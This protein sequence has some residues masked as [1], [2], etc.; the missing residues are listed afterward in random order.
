MVFPQD[1]LDLTV[2][3]ALDADLTA[4]PSTWVWTDITDFVEPRI[5][6]TG[7]GK[8][9]EQTKASS[10]KATLSVDNTDGRFVRR[11]PLSPYY[12][13]LR[14]G[15]PIRVT[16][17]D[18]VIDPSVRFR[19]FIAEL[20]PN[21]EGGYG[22]QWVE[23]TASGVLRRLDQI[24]ITDSALKRFVL[25]TTKLRAYWPLEDSSGATSG[26]SAIP[27]QNPTWANGSTEDVSWASASDLPGSGS[28]PSLGEGAQIGARINGGTAAAWIVAL[29]AKGELDSDSS[30]GEWL[31]ARIELTGTGVYYVVIGTDDSV[32]VRMIDSDTGATVTEVDTATLLGTLNLIG[33]W[34]TVAVAASGGTGNVTFSVFI[35]GRLGATLGVTG[36]GRS[37]GRVD[38]I[39]YPH[40]FDSADIQSMQVG[41]ITVWTNVGL[42]LSTDDIWRVAS[43]HDAAMGYAGE[44]AGDR[45]R[46]VCAEESIPCEVIEGVVV[47]NLPASTKMGPQEPA[48]IGALLE[49][50]ASA[51]EGLLY[52]DPATGGIAYLARS[53]LYER[54]VDTP[55]MILDIDEGDITSDF[56]VEDGDQFTVTDMTVSR[57]GG[58]SSRYT[59]V[60]EGEVPYP[61]SITL[62]L[63]SDGATWHHASW[64]VHMGT[65][66]EYRYPVIELDLG[67]R[68]ELIPA[69]VACGV[70][71]RIT[72]D[73]PPP[74]HPPDELDLIII[75]YSEILDGVDWKVRLN[76]APAR[77]YQMGQLPGTLTTV[78]E[79]FEDST[80]AF[81]VTDGGNA[82]WTR[83]QDDAHRGSWSWRSGVIADSESSDAIVTVP[84]GCTRVKFWYRVSCDGGFDF[85]R[86]IVG[87]V[88][89]L[90]DSGVSG[91]I[92]SGYID[93]T[94]GGTVTFRYIKNSSRAL[95]GDRVYVDDIQFEGGTGTIDNGR[96]RLDTAGSELASSVDADGTTMVVAT[97]QGPIW[98]SDLSGLVLPGT[99]GSYAS[100]PH[101]VASD[102]TAAAGFDAAGSDPA[103]APSVTA[104][105]P[106]LLVC[107]WTGSVTDGTYTIPGSMTQVAEQQGTFYGPS[108]VAIEAVTA[109]A[110][111][112]RSAT[113]GGAHDWSA[114]SVVLPGATV[115][116]TVWDTAVNAG[117]SVGTAAAETGWWVIAVHAA[118]W[119]GPD[120]MGPPDGSWDLIADSTAQ[121]SSTR[122]AV[123]A[124]QVTT[125]GV[126]TVTVDA[127][128]ANIDHFLTV[129]VVSGVVI[130]SGLDITGNFTLE[131]DLDVTDWS[132]GAT[133]AIVSKYL[134]TGNNRSY[135]MWISGA[136]AL[137]AVWSTDGTSAGRSIISSATPV[138]ARAAGV[139]VSLDVDSGSDHTVVFSYRESDADDWTVFDTQVIAGVTSVDAGTAA[140]E[141]GAHSGGT[142]D[143]LAG[144]VRAVR[145]YSDGTLIA[146]VR[147]NAQ[148]IG[149]TSF[150]DE[151]GRVWTVH[152]SAAIASL[153]TID[154][155]IGGEV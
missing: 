70:G 113:A 11:N 138:P 13:Q 2:E 75:G 40:I 51:D 27:G 45:I 76:C 34:H 120:A 52:E 146:D 33:N 54:A 19:G 38:R 97:T 151:D 115:E 31:Y 154:L 142:A 147:P 144:T 108:T 80:L 65:V 118:G 104:T 44:T 77:P 24:D 121:A 117:I 131:A 149:A 56:E 114:A 129:L 60:P 133:Q 92:Q 116:D 35:D 74:G 37:V 127:V 152:G 101:T 42:V 25:G 62:D 88:T 28:L 135:G 14:K 10:A 134:G 84:A 48:S 87:G 64:G 15:T 98:V 124:R 20:P 3:L 69:W 110:T 29:A 107:A 145:V 148:A 137:Q 32:R 72:I 139:R 106:G 61:R 1:V 5:N 141:I 143:P 67:S 125:P 68:P 119:D 83:T 49:A 130:D 63:A 47:G 89:R 21:W 57:S 95:F 18:G 22:D 46:R 90:E 78:S 96:S 4:D 50:A 17:S 73:H 128:T 122:T 58:S 94:P 26:A 123:W 53:A 23:I 55:A 71:S 150:T 43:Y 91:W 93:V 82:A 99:A 30:D 16:A 155:A 100:T 9:D 109:G 140:L 153:E 136:G 111:G 39:Y 36:T 41:H 59:A 8:S 12:G 79:G 102:I 81:T 6:I 7:V 85:F 86:V 132:S 105:V 66:D 103:V 112:T 126:Q